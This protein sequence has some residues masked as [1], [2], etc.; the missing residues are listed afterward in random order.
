MMMMR[1][2]ITVVLVVVLVDNKLKFLRVKKGF[3]P[4]LIELYYSFPL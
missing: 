1:W 4:N 3:L 2:D